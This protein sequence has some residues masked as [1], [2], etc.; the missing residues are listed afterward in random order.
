M[1]AAR[2]DNLVAVVLDTTVFHK[3]PADA[4]ADK[5]NGRVSRTQIR[6][7]R[8]CCDDVIH[9]HREAGTGDA[10]ARKQSPAEDQQ[11]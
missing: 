9:N 4:R 7:Q 11:R 2:F 6:D 1:L 8:G 3:T 10:K 5:P